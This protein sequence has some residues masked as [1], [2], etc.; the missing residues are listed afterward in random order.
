MMTDTI[1]LASMLSAAPDALRRAQRLE[2]AVSLL[3]SNVPELE[4]RKRVERR[5]K[6]SRWT[7]RRTV[8]MACDL[9]VAVA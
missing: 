1:M 6:C 5:W 4:V 7:A 9:A 8:E 3:R 2:F